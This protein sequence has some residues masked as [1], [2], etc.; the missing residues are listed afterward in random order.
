MPDSK[1]PSPFVPWLTLAS[2][3]LVIAIGAG[4]WL[5]RGARTAPAV[6]A[7]RVPARPEAKLGS[8]ATLSSA[9]VQAMVAAN[10]AVARGTAADLARARAAFEQAV[11]LDERY[12]PAHAGLTQALVLLAESGGERPSAVLPKAIE[13]GDRAVELDPAGARGWSALARAEVLWTRDWP[14]AEMH[15][16]RALALDPKAEAPAAW[17][18]ELLAA[19]GRSQEALEQSGHALALGAESAALLGSAGLVRHFLG[20]HPGAVEYLERARAAGAREPDISRHLA[21]TYAAMGRH[22]EALAAANRAASASE[23]ATWVIAYVHA[24][25]GRPG[26]AEAALAALKARAAQ[27]YV[28]SIEWAYVAAASGRRDDA[29]RLIETAVP[30]HSPGSEWLLVDPIFSPLRSE[31]RFQAVLATMKLGPAR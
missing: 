10:A 21:R 4:W 22:G 18:A 3:G 13:H 2:A 26:D 30:E 19:T 25:A 12:A 23:G 15:Y 14:R 7:T 1:T 29:L 20:D 17:L 8:Q 27:T 5:T 9:V 11:R 31:P 16:R 24:A 28:P 6:A